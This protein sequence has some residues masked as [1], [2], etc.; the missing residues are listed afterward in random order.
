MSNEIT[1]RTDIDAFLIFS[2][3]VLTVCAKVFHVYLSTAHKKFVCLTIL[4]FYPDLILNQD[5][6]IAV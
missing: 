4:P 2:F 6:N 3:A 5:R 1:D